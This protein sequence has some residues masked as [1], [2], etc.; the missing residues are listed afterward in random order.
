MNELNRRKNWI[1]FSKTFNPVISTTDNRPGPLE[2]A[3]RTPKV[4]VLKFS[5]GKSEMLIWNMTIVYK[6]AVRKYSH[7]AILVQSFRIF[8]FARTL[9]FDKFESADF[10]HDNNFVKSQSKNTQIRY[11]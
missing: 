8:I 3:D 4:F 1:Y 7:N 5:F 9:N 11:I 2:K 6:I 10:K